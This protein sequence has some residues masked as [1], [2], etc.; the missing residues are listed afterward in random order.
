M[1]KTFVSLLSGHAPYNSKNA[2]LEDFRDVVRN[3]IF[4]LGESLFNVV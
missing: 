3:I 2:V 1:F 4:E